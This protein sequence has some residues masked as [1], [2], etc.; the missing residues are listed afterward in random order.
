MDPEF[1]YLALSLTVKNRKER[2]Y[3][4]WRDGRGSRRGDDAFM[5]NRHVCQHGGGDDDAYGGETD[6]I[7][8]RYRGGEGAL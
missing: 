8:T 1:R 7:I 2:A 6:W 4:G 5:A 3:G